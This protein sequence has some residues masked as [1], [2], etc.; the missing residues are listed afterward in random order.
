MLCVLEEYTDVANRS[1][2]H[3]STLRPI[4]PE[5]SLRYPPSPAIS[6]PLVQQSDFLNAIQYSAATKID[7]NCLR[8]IGEALVTAAHGILLRNSLI[9]KRNY[10]D[11]FAPKEAALIE[12]NGLVSYL[13]CPH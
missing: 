9:N 4:T 12:V 11:P 10:E 6:Y 13:R 8:W 1:A 2:H 7:G 3:M 5:P